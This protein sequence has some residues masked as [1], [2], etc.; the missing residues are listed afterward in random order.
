[1]RRECRK[2]FPH[3]R[4]QRKPLVSYPSMHHGTCI[5]HVPWCMSGWLSRCG[6]EN[7]PG[8]SGA[9]ATR[10]CKGFTPTPSSGTPPRTRWMSSACWSQT[11]RVVY[12]TNC[13]T[14]CNEINNE[15][16]NIRIMDWW[17][18]LLFIKYCG[19]YEKHEK[20][21]P[22]L[23]RANAVF[24]ITASPSAR[25]RQLWRRTRNFLKNFLQFYV[26]D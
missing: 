9:C 14:S 15:I 16:N 7:I 1:M 11:L 25:S 5:M 17:M 13:S 22:H 6:G 21:F 10:T 8:I 26:Y 19:W 4:L 2:R 18:Y 23:S 24:Q 12:F 3:H 20:S